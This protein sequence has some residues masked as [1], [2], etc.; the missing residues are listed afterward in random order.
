MIVGKHMQGVIVGLKGQVAEIKFNNEQP[1]MY[2]I[3]TSEIDSNVLIEVISSSGRNTFFGLVLSPANQLYRGMIVYNTEKQL[4]IP[5]GEKVLGRVFD[6]FGQD[7][8]EDKDFEGAEYQSIHWQEKYNFDH[9][10]TPNQIL[11]T[12]IK[13][14]DF[15]TPIL[16]GG[17]VGLFG[18]AGVGKTILLTELINNIVILSKKKRDMAAV[19]SAVGERSREA[20][21]LYIRLKETKVIDQMSLVLGQMGENPAV[22]FRT[23]FAG[24]S[25]AAY[26][27]ESLKK[28]VLFLI[29]NVYRFAQAG[30]ELSIMMSAIPSED[31]YQPTLTSDMGSLHERLVSTKSGFVTAIEAVFV[32]SDDMTDFGVRSVFPYLDTFVVLSR[33][34]Y[35]QGRMPAIDLLASTSRALSPTITD[36]VHYEVYLEAKSLL[37]QAANLEKIVSLVGFSELSF[38]DQTVY[39]RAIL[40]KNYMTQTFHTVEDQTGRKGAYI[41]LKQTVTDVR[42]ILKG[43][44]DILHPEKLLFIGAIEDVI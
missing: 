30:H 18:G 31:G 33:A 19:F 28:D 27:R 1:A 42:N 34:V 23:A 36:K 43:K 22:R 9:V 8:M 32:P 13:A 6:I 12:G 10:S 16:K 11:E 4:S 40:L 26:F 24:A 17:K 41:T 2:D 15:F 25:L 20:Q 44:Y 35:Q 5:M 14:V 39:K 21:E 7:Q 29:D 37:E 38:D 3:L